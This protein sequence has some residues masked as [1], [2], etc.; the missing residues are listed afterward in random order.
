MGALANGGR[1]RFAAGA[2]DYQPDALPSS[3][4]RRTR[5]NTDHYPDAIWA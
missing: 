2:A 5:A 1:G 3:R 4:V